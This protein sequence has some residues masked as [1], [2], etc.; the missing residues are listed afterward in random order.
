MSKMIK[1]MVL[2]QVFVSFLV[3]CL[4]ACADE[5]PNN[6]QALTDSGEKVVLFPDGHWEYVDQKKAAIAKQEI[7]QIQNKNTCPPGTLESYFGLGCLIQSDKGGNHDAPHGK[8][9]HSPL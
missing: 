5:L 7:K 4:N 8:V 1:K 9:Y 3:I 2:V 6:I